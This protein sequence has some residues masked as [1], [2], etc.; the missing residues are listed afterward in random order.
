MKAQTVQKSDMGE[1]LYKERGGRFYTDFHTALSD[2]YIIE[3]FS[4]RNKSIPSRRNVIVPA[5][6]AHEINY[7]LYFCAI[8]SRS[9]DEYGESH[10]IIQS[11]GN[12][13]FQTEID[14]P[15]IRIS[16]SILYQQAEMALTGISVTK[17]YATQLT[18]SDPYT[19]ESQSNEP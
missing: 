18:Q 7:R 3:R 6:Q 17:I 19:S 5:K 8:Y 12:S 2:M 9:S 11:R 10:P 1:Y 16:K 13:K 14:R 15:Y 4:R